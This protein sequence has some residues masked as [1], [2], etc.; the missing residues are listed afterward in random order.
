MRPGAGDHRICRRRASRSAPRQNRDVGSRKHPGWSSRHRAISPDSDGVLP[1][2]RAEASSATSQEPRNLSRALP[3]RASLAKT[4]AR[5]R[6]V[7]TETSGVLRGGRVRGEHRRELV[8][9]ER[10]TAAR[11][12]NRPGSAETQ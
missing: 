6:D 3:I 4:A 10:G 2:R 7:V 11:H 12:D 8:I 9:V 1:C 5:P